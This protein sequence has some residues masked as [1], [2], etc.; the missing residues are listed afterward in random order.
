MIRM[1]ISKCQANRAPSEITTRSVVRL[2]LTPQRTSSRQFNKMGHR[3][4][5]WTNAQGPLIQTVILKPDKQEADR[6]RKM[7]LLS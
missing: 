7:I 1:I 4:K 2:H 6:A 5:A 3:I